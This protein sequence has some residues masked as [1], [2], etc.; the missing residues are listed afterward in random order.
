MSTALRTDFIEKLQKAAGFEAN[1]TYPLLFQH[2]GY[3]K[4]IAEQ[5][6][7][8][9]NYEEQEELEEIFNRVN[10]EIKLIIGLL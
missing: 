9:L 3:R 1:R 2:L 6:L 5:L 7:K 10:D 4:A 8:R